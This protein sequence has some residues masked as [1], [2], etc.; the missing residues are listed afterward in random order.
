MCMCW[1]DNYSPLNVKEFLFCL[2]E[3]QYLATHENSRI[4]Q[5]LS[6]LQMKAGYQ[7]PREWLHCYNNITP[8]LFETWMNKY[9]TPYKFPSII[10][11]LI[12]TCDRYKHFSKSVRTITHENVFEAFIKKKLSLLTTRHYSFFSTFKHKSCPEAD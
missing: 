1:G 5:K 12:H 2:L 7:K 10:I 8:A 6:Y 3:A 11:I 9:N 4:I